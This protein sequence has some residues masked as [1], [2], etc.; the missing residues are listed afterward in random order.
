MCSL[1]RLH[2][3]QHSMHNAI[4]WRIRK[5]YKSLLGDCLNVQNNSNKT[6]C[7]F[8]FKKAAVSDELYEFALLFLS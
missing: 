5:T 1:P 6:V 2:M 7:I 3:S 4:M 8:P